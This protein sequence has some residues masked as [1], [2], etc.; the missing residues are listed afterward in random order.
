MEEKRREVLGKG[1]G[2]YEMLECFWQKFSFCLLIP[3]FYLLIW[4][5]S[6]INLL[7][8]FNVQ[9]FNV[10]PLKI[11]IMINAVVGNHRWRFKL[12]INIGSIPVIFSLIVFLF[13]SCNEPSSQLSQGIL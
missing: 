8:G 3:C 6:N 11:V 4:T 12:S 1:K 5:I 7:K 2:M 10:I 9:N 13:D